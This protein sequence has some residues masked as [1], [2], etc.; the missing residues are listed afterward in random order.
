MGCRLISLP[1]EWA[2]HVQFLLVSWRIQ[3]VAGHTNYHNWLRDGP[4][5]LGN[6]TSAPADVVRVHQPRAL[7]IGQRIET[8]QE[9]V[10]LISKIRLGLE[11]RGLLMFYFF[12][13]DRLASEFFIVS[14]SRA[15]RE[16]GN[17][18]CHREPGMWRGRGVVVTAF[19]VHVGV[20][21]LALGFRDGDLPG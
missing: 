21:C 2:T 3:D 19:P 7:H 5:S 20:D 8:G 9:F 11:G 12:S 17:L 16:H 14:S 15:V 18:P 4:Q 10:P 1:F 13:G 6:T